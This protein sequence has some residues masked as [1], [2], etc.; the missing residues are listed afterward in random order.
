MQDW[1]AAQQA[2]FPALAPCY[3][4]ERSAV[5]FLGVNMSHSK[6]QPRRSSA[7]MA[8]TFV[9]EQFPSSKSMP[10]GNMVTMVEISRGK[11]ARNSNLPNT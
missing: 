11:R 2:N 8:P 7:S 5:G 9:V 4:L 3:I 1:H 6:L 10:V